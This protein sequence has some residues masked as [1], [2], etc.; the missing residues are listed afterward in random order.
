MRINFLSSINPQNVPK[1]DMSKSF[2]QIGERLEPRFD[3]RLGQV[4]ENEM[5]RSAL[6]PEKPIHG[7]G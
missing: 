1:N 7:A 2:D 4:F 6:S 5:Q 3:K